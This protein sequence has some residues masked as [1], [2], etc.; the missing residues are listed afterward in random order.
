VPA[1]FLHE[2]WQMPR[3]EQMKAR[4]V[5]G[6]DYPPPLVDHHAGRERVLEAYRLSRGE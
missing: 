2:P 6:E 1:E 4:C 5:L 3:S